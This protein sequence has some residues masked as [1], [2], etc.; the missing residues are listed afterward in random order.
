MT[1]ANSAANGASLED[2]HTNLFALADVHGIKWRRFSYQYLSAEPVGP[3]EDPVLLAY[4]QCLALNM[5]SAW[6]R[7]PCTKVSNE[8]G[9][10]GGQDKT[11]QGVTKELWIYWYGDDPNFSEIIPSELHFEEKKNWD[12]GLSYECRTL[13]FKALHNLIERN[14][15]GQNFVR[16]GKWFVRPYE[17]NSMNDSVTDHLSVSFSFFLHGE[18]TVCTAV[19]INQHH[20]IH[21]L[22]MY[23]LNAALESSTDFQVILCPYGLAGILTGQ[24]YNGNEQCAEKVLSEWKQF[25]PLAPGFTKEDPDGEL[26][27]NATPAVVEVLVGGVRM[28]Y[29][30]NYVVVPHN[31]ELPNQQHPLASYPQV[32]L[33]PKGPVG[34]LSCP[35]V[36]LTPPT[37]PPEHQLPGEAKIT[38]M[39][40]SNYAS[41]DMGM[42]ADF[43]LSPSAIAKSLA[44]QVWKD[45]SVTKDKDIDSTTS[46]EALNAAAGLDEND[47][48]T[49]TSK[50]LDAIGSWHFTEPTRRASCGCTRNRN[51]KMK[52]ALVPL[53]TK[54]PAANSPPTKHKSDSK[55]DKQQQ[56]RSRPITLFH[57]R[58][59]MA[60]DFYSMEQEAMSHRLGVP[61]GGVVSMD[62]KAKPGSGNHLMRSDSNQPQTP[63]SAAPSP[64][65]APVNQSL[66]V[67]ERTMPT[68]SPYPPPTRAGSDS[69]TPT[70]G[71]A[72]VMK[73]EPYPVSLENKDHVF[74]ELA[75][76]ERTSNKKSVEADEKS[77][78][79]VLWRR[80]QLPLNFKRPLLPKTNLEMD[81]Q[82]DILLD[83]LYEADNSDEVFYQPHKK[84]R[85]EKTY[86]Y[87][88]DLLPG[89]YDD[90]RPLRLPSPDI[91]PYAFEESDI[92]SPNS[93]RTMPAYKKANA[94]VRPRRRGSF[95]AKPDKKK[96][97]EE[98]KQR[99]GC[100][101]D[102]LNS[103][104][105]PC[106]ASPTD[107]I[108]DGGQQHMHQRN[109]S[110]FFHETDLAVTN[111]DLD[112]LFDSDGSDDD[113][114]EPFEDLKTPGPTIDDNN[115][116]CMGNSLSSS[117][118]VPGTTGPELS[119]MFPTPPSL[120][121][122]H[123]AF[124]PVTP[125]TV[126]YT[127]P[128]SAGMTILEPPVMVNGEL[129]EVEVDE[130]MGSPKPH[131]IEDWTYVFKVSQVEKFVG[132]SM[133]APLKNLPSSKLP[134]FRIPDNC[135]YK[136]SWQLPSTKVDYPMSIKDS[137]MVGLIHM[138]HGPGSVA[139]P[140]SVASMSMQSPAT[141]QEPR[142]AHNLEL[143]SPASEASSYVKNLNSIE[144]PA[145]TSV[146]PEVDSVLVNLILS[147]SL[148]NIYKDRN[149]D[150][151]VICACNMNIKGADAGMYLPDNFA[152]NQYKC[153]CGFS[154]VMNRK[155][156]LVSGLFAEDESEVTGQPLNGAL[157]ACSK[158]GL[159]MNP[160]TGKDTVTKGA[161]KD[162]VLSTTEN[163][164][165]MLQEQCNSP[166][167]TL[168]RL[169]SIRSRS[170][171]SHM[172]KL[173]LHF[174]IEDGCE[175]CYTAIEEGRQF[176]EFGSS[177][178]SHVLKTELLHRWAFTCHP[179]KNCL[180]TQGLMRALS[181]MQPLLQDAVLK[182]GNRRAWE[183]VYT[184]Q[185][186]LTWQFFFN[187]AIK[188]PQ[189]SSQP[190]PIPPLLVG[191]DKEWLSFSPYA[192]RKWEKLLL[193][194]YSCPRDIAYL[195]VAPDDKFILQKAKAFFKE[196]SAVYETCRLGRHVP[197]AYKLRDGIYRI[198]KKAAAKLHH[199]PVDSWFTDL[200]SHPD[201]SKL[202]L[203]AQ[204]CK[205]HVAPFLM[206]EQIDQTIFSRGRP[207]RVSGGGG[208]GAGAKANNTSTN[209]YNSTAAGGRDGDMGPPAAPAQTGCQDNA[210]VVDNKENPSFSLSG[211]NTD[212]IHPPAIVIYMIDPFSSNY[213]PAGE[214]N[215][216]AT[217]GLVRCFMEMFRN[218]DEKLKR[219]V[220]LQIVPV[221][222]IIHTMNSDLNSPSLDDTK[223]LAFSVFSQCRKIVTP[224]LLSNSMTGFGPTAE[225]E[226]ILKSKGD[227]ASHLQRLYT[228]P[229]VLAPIKDKQTELGETFGERQQQW[230]ELFCVYCL[231]HDQRWILATCTDNKGET[232]DTKV[233]SIDVPN[234]TRRKKVSV[235][236]IALGKVWD[237]MMEVM[238][239]AAHPWRLVVGR[240]GRLG[241]GELKDW[242][243][244]L[245]RKSLAKRTQQ[246]HG[247]CSM[248]NITNNSEIPCIL[249]ACLVSIEPEATLKLMSDSA[250]DKLSKVSQVQQSNNTLST[251]KDA[252]CTH[253]LVFPTSATTQGVTHNDHA[254]DSISES[255]LQADGLLELGQ[256]E[257]PLDFAKLFDLPSS[258]G[259][260]DAMMDE[261]LQTNA[262]SSPTHRQNSFQGADPAVKNPSGLHVLQSESE[263]AV[264]QQPLALG[265]FISTAQTGPLPKWFW[266]SCP[267][268]ENSCPV[269]LKAA[270][271][272][273]TSTE[274]Q[275]QDPLQANKQS[276]H[277]LDS[278]L[279]TDVLRYVLE[280]Y[281]NLSWLSVDPATGDRQSCL[282]VHILVLMQLY[283]TIAALL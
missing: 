64:L 47:T 102:Q 10:P 118:G 191:H 135:Y 44:N 114:G 179:Q 223:C 25:F 70:A 36:P 57:H 217:V 14:L 282:P 245:N 147:D 271:H 201:A 154:A 92:T 94:K 205:H 12:D 123:T 238:C 226:A 153:V 83:T 227:S 170:G 210:E 164:V 165:K 59:P 157:W 237:F 213:E 100:E 131:I 73:T 24:Y 130:D 1:A 204:V 48:E 101:T 161:G 255:M 53:G 141:F 50:L 22:S 183:K 5:L 54:V 187:C 175:A 34:P 247:C 72:P 194:P 171:H 119:Q 90:R 9:T 43:N 182:R 113:P 199:E 37:S 74:T 49:Q 240:F 81:D 19:A 158:A 29:P 111:R 152:H 125:G 143:Q 107:P 203:Y 115:K 166:Y 270:L 46:A 13:L 216:L 124:S 231:S 241:H 66:G 68:L 221:S 126:E 218:L 121:Q 248:C 281:N 78:D 156:A 138:D 200:G 202:K 246:L 267:E 181:S 258:P 209:M 173:K 283:N 52:A 77:E 110:S 108:T 33:P 262:A 97:E 145:S 172:E 279:T 160:T 186:P 76:G 58:V 149:F 151:C 276:C 277:P 137:L 4:S 215:T 252:T 139:R 211:D 67:G 41:A 142:S 69:G 140:A 96:Q 254:F 148:M 189:Q 222:K 251:P 155:C 144:A 65:T 232:M 26:D 239:K 195:V 198:G 206:N 236:E 176:A 150:S 192:L 250:A 45:C 63:Q 109:S 196:L 269:F 274:H 256:D 106:L 61:V 167:S 120:E 28:L 39:Q 16:I 15:L 128:G 272:V 230:G 260:E 273:N 134:P 178:P 20:P 159:N 163:L 23:H 3:L 7:V 32:G 86:L 30:S 261:P 75:K 208:G 162:S 117:T 185:G 93:G 55:Q 214:Y 27:D 99:Q 122:Q 89:I 95:K 207:E 6:R 264:L 116:P 91:D 168:C 235:R 136:A 31:L 253:I 263:E 129:T 79:E 242:N 266:A 220:V 35:S 225:L 259:L 275:S 257:G 112:Q 224:T 51:S 2:C 278:N 234:H 8:P 21:H 193:E 88:S 87:R 133:Y 197:I 104:A 132:P 84:L 212:N 265:Y 103:G 56:Q 180:T 17:N 38:V 177:R 244:L 11:E 85:Q 127:N 190:L 18:S 105:L 60:E 71:N 82:A 188:G 174:E 146:Y 98:M 219:S 42:P 249:S 229:Y 233:I 62:S 243:K 169:N 268:A 280:N 80:F 228:P 40:T 184:V